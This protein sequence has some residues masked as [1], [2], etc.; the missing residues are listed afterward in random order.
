[1]AGNKAPKIT[2]FDTL[3]A[4][5]NATLAA[6]GPPKSMGKAG[7]GK[8]PGKILRGKIGP[9]KAG[10]GKI[11]GKI[12]RGKAGSSITKTPQKMRKHPQKGLSN[13]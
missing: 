11:P 7:P 3:E 13:G 9:G 6:D 10:P 5:V 12:V 2:D 1:M 4:Y 8:I